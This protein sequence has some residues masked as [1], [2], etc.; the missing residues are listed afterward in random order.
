[1]NN[2]VTKEEIRQHALQIQQSM[3]FEG[4]HIDLEDVVRIG[5]EFYDSD[6]PD[7]IDNLFRKASAENRPHLDVVK[8]HFAKT[9]PP[10]GR[11]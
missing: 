8:K 6:Q 4:F 7:T 3:A 11:D 2:K 5:Q 1:M 9:D 10:E